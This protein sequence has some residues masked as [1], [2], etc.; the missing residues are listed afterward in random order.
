MTLC[1]SIKSSY[2]LLVITELIH[3]GGYINKFLIPAILN[4][5]MNTEKSIKSIY[6]D[7]GC[8]KNSEDGL[9]I[10]YEVLQSTFNEKM[11]RLISIDHRF[12][13]QSEQ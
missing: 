11:H 6:N 1:T 3:R 12:E 7:L 2:T 9:T 8:F 4:E 10:T 5:R 13:Y